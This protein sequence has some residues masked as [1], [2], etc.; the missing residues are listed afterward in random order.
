MVF[1]LWFS[2]CGGKIEKEEGWEG[3]PSWDFVADG[4]CLLRHAGKGIKGRIRA[5][6]LRSCLDLKLLL[7]V[8]ERG[9]ANGTYR[10]HNIRVSTNFCFGE[11][12]ALLS[13]QH[14]MSSFEHFWVDFLGSFFFAYHN[15]C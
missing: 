14:V 12:A 8:G 6:G 10:D 15:L 5:K 13:R 9:T 2:K 11:S 7:L 4:V 3:G 1:G